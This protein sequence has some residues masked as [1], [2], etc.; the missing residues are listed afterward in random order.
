MKKLLC[1]ALLLLA[2]PA[3]AEGRRDAALLRRN[4]F[5]AHVA[6]RTLSIDPGQSKPNR[7]RLSYT[8]GGH[9]SNM[10]LEVNGT[11]QGSSR[12]LLAPGFSRDPVVVLGFADSSGR[13]TVELPEFVEWTGT[14]L[15]WLPQLEVGPRPD[16]GHAG[17]SEL[18]RQAMP[19]WQ[20][21]ES[22]SRPLD[23]SARQLRFWL[24]TRADHTHAVVCTR[25]QLSSQS[26]NSPI[27]GGPEP[28]PRIL[29]VPFRVWKQGTVSTLVPGP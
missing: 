27:V 17:G 29:N 20:V 7:Y 10:E 26:L 25:Q 13:D 18:F 12:L 5:G 6:L 8:A 3:L 19:L 2:A 23:T 21:Q 16:G 24:V 15:R 28:Q 9:S 14:R 22:T 4:A 1:C 11:L